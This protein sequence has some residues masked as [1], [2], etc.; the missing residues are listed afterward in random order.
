MPAPLP[1]KK[2]FGAPRQP[3]VDWGPATPYPQAR[4]A[5]MQDFQGDGS[6]MLDMFS[7]QVNELS[8]FYHWDEQETYPQARAHLWGTALAY[9]RRA[10]FPPRTWEELKT[11]LMKHF[12]PRDLTATY[13]AQF[14]S[15][16]RRQ[17]EDIYTYVG[18]LQHLADLAWPFMDYHAKE[19]MVVDPFLLEMGNYELSVEV[20]AHGHRRVE[21]IPEWLDR[22]RLSKRRKSFIL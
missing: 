14:R 1:R 8:R 13:K 19:E 5:Q 17:T 10:P 11:L 16:R 9:I 18:T 15:C 6:V 12:Q 3:V 20:A 7:D 4:L 22:W 2:E 21:E